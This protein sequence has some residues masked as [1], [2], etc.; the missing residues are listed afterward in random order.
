MSADRELQSPLNR[1]SDRTA[2][3]LCCVGMQIGVSWAEGGTDE[4]DVPGDGRGRVG[5]RGLFE[6][7]TMMAGIGSAAM[8]IWRSRWTRRI[9]SALLFFWFAYWTWQVIGDTFSAWPYHL[10]VIGGPGR[11]TPRLIPGLRARSGSTFCS[12][13]RRPPSWPSSP[14]FGSPSRSSSSPGLG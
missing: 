1:T 8:R 12:P 13:A 2:V 3:A 4:A 11:P 10:D 5:R 14:S 6:R 9:G 7:G